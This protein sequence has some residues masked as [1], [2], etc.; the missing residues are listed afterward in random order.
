MQ[1]LI[2]RS[3]TLLGY[4]SDTC[5]IT[6]LDNFLIPVRYPDRY[7]FEGSWFAADSP[8]TVTRPVSSLLSIPD[9]AGLDTRQSERVDTGLPSWPHDTGAAPDDMSWLYPLDTHVML[10]RSSSTR[11]LARARFVF[12]LGWAT[13]GHF[14]SRCG[15]LRRLRCVSAAAHH[16]THLLPISR[17]LSCAFRLPDGS[18]WLLLPSSL[19]LRFRSPT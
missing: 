16:L 15:P 5:W 17:P 4:V 7:G 1:L 18:F 8:I 9:K 3:E 19:P 10:W 6:L 11:K 2:H 13:L 14:R 12:P